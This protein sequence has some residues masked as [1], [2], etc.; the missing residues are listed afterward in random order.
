MGI[1]LIAGRLLLGR[2]ML[3]PGLFMGFLSKLPILPVLT[4]TMVVGA[5]IL[6]YTKGSANKEISQI[7]AD[8]AKIEKYVE[9]KRKISDISD[10]DLDDRLRK[11]TRD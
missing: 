8:K 10:A 2:L 9:N 1:I 5:F 6:G 11:Y 7:K 3:L 4:M